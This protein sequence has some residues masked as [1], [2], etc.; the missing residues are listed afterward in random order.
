MGFS[1]LQIIN[2]EFKEENSKKVIDLI[3]SKWSVWFRKINKESIE[4]EISD[5]NLQEEDLNDFKVI[6]KC[7]NSLYYKKQEYADESFIWEKEND[8][9]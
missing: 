5:W 9:R 2:L 3:K 8:R 7:I 1:N 4:F 6:C